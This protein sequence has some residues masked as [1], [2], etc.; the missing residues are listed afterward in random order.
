MDVLTHPSP[1]LKQHAAPVDPQND[2]SLVDLCR[3]MAKA[4]YEAPGIGIAAPQIGVLKRVIVYD[5]ED[6][7]N[8]IALCNPRIIETGD[9]LEVDDEGCLSLPGITVAVE[10]PVRVVCEAVSMKGSPVVLE[11]EGLH[12][13][14]LQHEIDHLDGVLIIDRATAEERKAALRR[15]REARDAGAQPGDVSI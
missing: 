2:N 9:E 4:M 12:A 3:T 6:E 11:A 1:A 7:G 13:R 10:R 15:Y 5:L 8:P 14:L